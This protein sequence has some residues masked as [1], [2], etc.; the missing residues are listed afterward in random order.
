MNTTKN[1]RVPD[2]VRSAANYYLSLGYKPVPVPRLGRCKAPVLDAWQDLRPTV[3]DLATLFPRDQELNLGLLLGE[4]SGG[5][6]DIDLDT[7]EAV[8][9]A[10]LLL[11]AT[12]WISGRAGKPRSH[13]W[14]LVD[15]PPDKASQAFTDVDVDK[16]VLLEV[17]STRAQTIVPPGRHESGEEI[18]WHMH[19]EPAKAD[20]R[21]LEEAARAVAAV[22]LL[23]R[24]WPG[25]S[26]RQFAFLHLAGGLLR[27]GWSEERAQ[28]FVE[29][30]AAVTGDEEA[31]KRSLT[32]AQTARKMEE[33]KKI[34]GWPKLEDLLGLAGRE[35]VWSVR[36]WLGFAPAEG[37]SKKV[38]TLEPYQPFPVEALPAPIAEY[39][40]QGALALGCDAAFLALPALAM[41]ASVIGNTRTLRLKRGWEEPSIVWSAV[42]ADSGTLKSP[43]YLKVMGYLFRL[44]KRLL[45]EYTAKAAKYH[46]DLQAYKEAKRTAKEE[47]TDPGE[48]P[49][50]P[51]LLRVVCSDTTIEKLAEILQDN[52][53]GT[54]V[55]RDELAGWLGSFT[56]YK[57]KQGNTDLPNWLE[58][59]RAGTVIIDR[60]TTERKTLFIPRAAASVTGGIQPG[61]LTRALTPEFL[62]AGLA[63]RLLMAMPPKLKK[64]W[65]EVEV[66]PD[67]E[68]A[69]HDAIDKL[70]A[71]DFDTHD[72]EKVPYALKLSREGKEAWVTFYNAWAKEQAAAEGELAAAF[73]K[74]EAY[75]ARFALL[76]HVV[77][78][79]WLDVDDR[80][81]VGVRS[82][83]AG[84]TLCRWFATEARRIYKTLSE[85]NDQRDTRRL[86]EFI[87]VRGG[88]ITV[89]NLQRSNSRKYPTSEEAEQALSHLVDAGHADWQ[90]RLAPAQG[91][92][93]TR[94][95]VLKPLPTTDDTD[96][97]PD[98]DE[99]GECDLPTIPSDDT[100][101]RPQNPSVS[102]GIVGI[103]GSRSEGG[104]GL[105]KMVHD[106][107][108]LG[109]LGFFESVA[110]VDR[111]SSPEAWNWGIAHG[112]V[113]FGSQEGPIHNAA[114]GSGL[115]PRS[116]SR[117]LEAEVPE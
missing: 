11:P 107:H 18:V 4:P 8:M 77:S 82:I 3:G 20:R 102:E 61:V 114:S 65:T 64:R 110:L 74:L 80:R 28:R 67:A 84:V 27:G 88:R 13:R 31:R 5:L 116:E 24:H 105:M 73:S 78:C 81:E 44:Q 45:T 75:A 85:S 33:D 39:V 109:L 72:G 99:D 66:D 55:A 50:P 103:V 104:G 46:E 98:G 47:G 106:F 115:V 76:H 97:T 17:R 63:A 2:D 9:A 54:L 43:A 59:F 60:K 21:E 100:P 90:P 79:T 112:C 36:Q 6:V 70:L 89:K 58:M 15:D 113:G 35:V 30:L 34:T 111:K 108:V 69:F 32:V 83:Q 49:E 10:P 48:P 91:G 117:P 87:Q 68:Q 23:A 86:V 57:G 7:R 42:V 37:S 22:A 51:V 1:G 101:P 52:V 14:F 41:V 40:R 62:D 12:G 94:D 38:R 96:D 56:R 19:K 95:C 26:S 92:K 25:K 53:R 16:T 29:A 71:L 93:P